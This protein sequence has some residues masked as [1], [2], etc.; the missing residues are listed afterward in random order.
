MGKTWGYGYL[1]GDTIFRQRSLA[2]I[3]GEELDGLYERSVVDKMHP[4]RPADCHKLE[5][6]FD[7]NYEENEHI[8]GRQY[9]NIIRG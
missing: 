7:R 8:V 3:L 2:E 4:R 9:R 1:K 5:V 6:Y